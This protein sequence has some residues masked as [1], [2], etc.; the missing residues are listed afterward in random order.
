MESAT[1]A[2]LAMAGL[3]V[4][5]LEK[6]HFPREKVCGDGLTPRA[7]RELVNLG[8]PT[9]RGRLDPQQGPAHHRCGHAL[10]LDWPENSRLPALRHG[11][12]AAWTSTT[13]SPS[14]RSR[15]GARLARAPTSPAPITDALGAIIGV[16]A[17]RR[18][19]ERPRHGRDP[20]VPRAPRRGGDGNSC[21]LVTGHGPARSATTAP[22]ASPS[23]PTT[24]ARAP[25]TTTSRPARAVGQGRRRQGVLLPGYGWI[26]GVERRHDQRRPRHPQ[27]HQGLRQRRL[28]GRHASLGRDDARGVEL[29]RR[30]DDAADPRRRAADGLQPAAALRRRAAAR[31]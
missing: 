14:T 8:I 25:T 9:P 18:R 2:Y 19:R 17:K 31:R 11:A 1:A 23:G 21:R 26:F 24:R 7:V 28:Q 5:L 4:L 22:W 13:S 10:Q 3:D 15:T 6:T 12:H 29:E 30:D 16:T 20:R 27:H